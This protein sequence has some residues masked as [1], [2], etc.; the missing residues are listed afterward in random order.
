MPPKLPNSFEMLTILCHLAGQS[1]C[2]TQPV[3]HHY[4]VGFNAVKKLTHI[5]KFY[6]AGVPICNLLQLFDNPIVLN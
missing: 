5:H 6:E 3:R 4:N 2:R 1:Q